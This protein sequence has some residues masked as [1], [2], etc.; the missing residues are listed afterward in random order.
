MAFLATV[1]AG[2]V[3]SW[4]GTVSTHVSHF[5]TVE[6]ATEASTLLVDGLSDLPFHTGLSAITGMVAMSS[7]VVA[8][9]LVFFRHDEHGRK[10]WKE[11]SEKRVLSEL[12]VSYLCT[13]TEPLRLPTRQTQTM[14]YVGQSRAVLY[15]YGYMWDLESVSGKRCLAKAAHC[16]T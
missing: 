11:K 3:A 14:G 4:L 8:Q 10:Y 12:Y 9:S 13:P 7:T 1:V 15:S 5:A 2:L 6:A 16:A